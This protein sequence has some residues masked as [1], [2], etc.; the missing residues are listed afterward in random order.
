MKYIRS[1]PA[2]LLFFLF[3]NFP[4]SAQQAPGPLPATFL[5]RLQAG[6]VTPPDSLKPWIYYYWISDHVSKEGITKDLEAM[7]KIGIGEALIGD[8]GLDEVPPGKVKMLSE[9]WWQLTE[10]AIR[11][12]GRLGVKIGLFNS[13]GWSQSG[14]PWVKPGEAMRY[15]VYKDTVLKGPAA[16][17][18]QLK[19]PHD[20]FQDVALLAFPQPAE[21]DHWMTADHPTVT[22]NDSTTPITTLT[23]GLLSTTFATDSLTATRPVRIQLTTSN[24]LHP[25]TLFLYPSNISFMADVELQ[26]LRNGT[27]ATIEQFRYDR[28]NYALNVGPVPQ[29]VLAVALPPVT[30]SSFRLIF[31][32]IRNRNNKPEKFGLAEI[33]L[34]P[35][36]AIDRFAEKQLDKMYPTP[37]P[38]WKEYQWPLLPEPDA[39]G[40]AVDASRVVNLTASMDTTGRLQWQVPAGNWVLM[41][42][43]VTPTGTQNAP[44]APY[45]RGLEVDKMNKLHLQAHFDAYIGE[46]LRRMPPADRTAFTH[47]IADS[48]EM[49]SEN[50]TEGMEQRFRNKFGYDPLPYLPVISGRIVESR[51]KSDRFLWDLRRLIADMVASEYVGGLRELSNKAGLRIWLENYGHW[52]FP[53]EFLQYGGQS[54]D[55]AG[56]F[57]NEG[58]LGNI[59]CKAASSAAHIYGHTKV[60]AESFT[61]GGKAYQRTP[62]MLKKRGDWSF[63]EGINHVL[64]H[65][66][67]H[68][69]Y[70]NKS[71]GINAPFG[72]EFNRKNTLFD[73]S[74]DWVDYERRCMLLLQQGRAVSDVCYFIGEDAPKMTGV[75]DP[76]LPK[77]YSFDYIN[78][79]VVM[80]RLQVNEGRLVLPDGMSYRMMVLPPLQTITP[81][82]LAK[83]EELVKDGAVV[84][85]PKPLRSPGLEH[86]PDADRTVRELADKL[87]GTAHEK[88]RPYGKGLLLSNMTMPEALAAVQLIPDLGIPDHVPV[89]F[90]HRS[91]PGADIYFLTN[92]SDSTVLFDAAFRGR[93][94]QAQFWDAT[95]GT[96]R[97]L[98][99]ATA[100]SQTTLLPITLAPAQSGFVVFPDGGTPL[101]TGTNF[102]VPDTLLTIKTPWTLRFDTAM[103]GPAKGVLTPALKSWSVSTDPRI[104]YYSGKVRYRNQFTLKA[105]PGAGQHV[106][107]HTGGFN[108]IAK[109]FVNGQ[110]ASTIWTAPWQADVTSL[111]KKGANKLTIEFVSTWVNR[112]IGDSGLPE[113]DR[114]TWMPV[115][116]YKPEDH[117]H[118]AGLTMPVKILEVTY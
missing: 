78:A 108:G 107:V 24:T 21:D 38:Y 50:W 2:A 75:R 55:I 113:K 118:P 74:K 29:A 89:L 48:Y 10:H 77:G 63:T 53:A 103:R 52:G 14:G 4:A 26:V 115:N 39:N 80:T 36:A 91:M 32:D 5:S 84:L 40:L 90:T 23:D 109:V 6:F 87:W 70:E 59:E 71:P 106:F 100:L 7:A 111:V 45:A 12:G 43:G 95:N 83:I 19:A 9:E 44:T 42:I 85:G 110:E 1:V 65:L 57:W 112:L 11:E 101:S 72:T 64:L 31:T 61:S 92:Q 62:A 98:P 116:P 15:L 47:V 73:F 13:P 58:E 16:F 18:G 49:G 60:Y 82:V 99:Q 51:E 27:Y 76:A 86:Y 33:A 22:L 30:G 114:I 37:L 88:N 3:F 69:P 28:S 105:L 25:R 81:Q 46:L 20:T 102:P 94:A 56:E 117:L 35:A 66:Y 54:D 68:Q 104:R 93:Y 96:V 8:I 97:A 79:E 67:I 41:R 17:S 34:S